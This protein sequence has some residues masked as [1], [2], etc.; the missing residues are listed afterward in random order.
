MIRRS[1]QRDFYFP[2]KLILDSDYLRTGLHH[3]CK[4]IVDTEM[5]FQNAFRHRST[6]SPAEVERCKLQLPAP[7]R[8]AMI[9]VG[10]IPQGRG[11]LVLPILPSLKCYSRD[12]R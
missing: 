4:T 5:P 9:L 3:L 8:L 1:N 2:Y 10:F 11:Q 7:T 6:F 12:S